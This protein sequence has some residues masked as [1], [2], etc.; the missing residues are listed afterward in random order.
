MTIIR[1]TLAIWLLIAMAST[2]IWAFAFGEWGYAATSAIMWAL[3]C[4]A[5]FDALKP[6]E[7]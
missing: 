1:I 4:F 2:L 5:F 6:R 3:T 7:E